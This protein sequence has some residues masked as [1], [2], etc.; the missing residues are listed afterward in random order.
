M[1]KAVLGLLILLASACVTRA[2]PIIGASSG[3]TTYVEL[4]TFDEG[5][6]ADLTIVTDQFQHLGVT[7]DPPGDIQSVAGYPNFDGRWLN[8]FNVDGS[9]VANNPFSIHFEDIVTAATFALITNP[10]M[11]TFTALLDGMIVESF[12]AATT[13]DN[14][15]NYFGFENIKFDEIQIL[16]PGNGA[17]GIDN[18]AYLPLPAPVWMLLAAL[19]ALG[20]VGIWRRRRKVAV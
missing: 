4:I 19:S 10:G 12:M 5:E 20:I 2:D 18:L 6:L 7:F 15:F 8:N 14:A 17:L 3:L 13:F 1:R 9:G 11:T 16:A